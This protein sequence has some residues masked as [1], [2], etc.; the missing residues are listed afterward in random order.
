MN[1]YRITVYVIILLILI[2]LIYTIF[3]YAKG[4]MKEMNVVENFSVL[5]L[6]LQASAINSRLQASEIALEERVAPPAT[7]PVVIYTQ[8]VTYPNRVPYDKIFYDIVEISNVDIMQYKWKTM[9]YYNDPVKIVDSRIILPA[10][11]FTN[12]GSPKLKSENSQAKANGIFGKYVDVNKLN[13]DI[14]YIGASIVLARPNIHRINL[15]NFILSKGNEPTGFNLSSDETN[16]LKNTYN[17]LYEINYWYSITKTFYFDDVAIGDNMDATST[18]FEYVKYIYDPVKYVTERSNNIFASNY[19]DSYIKFLNTKL[20]YDYNSLNNKLKLIYDI[21]NGDITKMNINYNKNGKSFDECKIT[22]PTSPYHSYLS[23][24]DLLNTNNDEFKTNVNIAADLIM[25]QVISKNVT[26]YDSIFQGTILASSNEVNIKNTLVNFFNNFY[27]LN[28][29]YAL[30]AERYYYLDVNYY[31]TTPS[32]NV[33]LSFDGNNFIGGET[34]TTSHSNWL[35]GIGLDSKNRN[36]FERTNENGTRFDA[37]STD[38]MVYYYGMNFTP[39]EAD[40]TPKI[41]I[42]STDSLSDQ[43]KDP[44]LPIS[45]LYR[46]LTYV[47]AINLIDDGEAIKQLIKDRTVE[48]KKITTANEKFNIDAGKSITIIKNIRKNIAVRKYLMSCKYDDFTRIADFNNE[49]AAKHEGEKDIDTVNTITDTLDEREYKFDSFSMSIFDMLP[50]SLHR[51]TQFSNR[52]LEKDRGFTLQNIDNNFKNLDNVRTT[53]ALKVTHKEWN[54]AEFKDVDVFDHYEIS[55]LS[56]WMGLGKGLETKTYTQKG[57]NEMAKKLFESPSGLGYDVQWYNDSI[58]YGFTS[59]VASNIGRQFPEGDYKTK[60]NSKMVGWAKAQATQFDGIYSGIQDYDWK[61]YWKYY[62]N[63]PKKDQYYTP[64]DA[65]S[66]VSIQTLNSILDAE[67][68]KLTELKKIQPV[69]SDLSLEKYYGS[70]V[71]NYNNLYSTVIPNLLKSCITKLKNNITEID[72]FTSFM[73]SF[74]DLKLTNYKWETMTKSYSINK[75][76]NVMY[77]SNSSGIVNDGNVLFKH[78]EGPISFVFDSIKRKKSDNDD[79]IINIPNVG[80]SIKCAEYNLLNIDSLMSMLLFFKDINN[81]AIDAYTIDD[82]DY[83][84]YIKNSDK[85]VTSGILQDINAF[86]IRNFTDMSDI[87]SDM[88]SKYVTLKTEIEK[89]NDKIDFLP[90]FNTLHKTLLSK[91][92]LLL[93]SERQSKSVNIAQYKEFSLM[94]NRFIK[95]LDTENTFWNIYNDKIESNS[96]LKK[97]NPFLSESEEK[98]KSVLSFFDKY[99]SDNIL[100]SKLELNSLLTDPKTDFHSLLSGDGSNDPKIKKI[101]DAIETWFNYADPQNPGNTTKDRFYST[102]YNG[103]LR[104]NFFKKKYNDGTKIDFLEKKDSDY[105]NIYNHPKILMT[106]NQSILDNKTTSDFAIFDIGVILRHIFDYD[107]TDYLFER[108]TYSNYNFPTWFEYNSNNIINIDPN[109]DVLS[110]ENYKNLMINSKLNNFFDIVDTNY[111]NLKQKYSDA[112][113]V[114]FTVNFFNFIEEEKILYS[115]ITTKLDKIV[116]SRQKMNEIIEYSYTDKFTSCVNCLI[117]FYTDDTVNVIIPLYKQLSDMFVVLIEPVYDFDSEEFSKIKRHVED[118]S[119]LNNDEF[120]N[121]Y[122]K[123]TRLFKSLNNGIVNQSTDTPSGENKKTSETESKIEGSG[124]LNYLFNIHNFVLNLILRGFYYYNKQRA[125]INKYGAYCRNTFSGPFVDLV[126]DD[127]NTF[128]EPSNQIIMD[129]CGIFTNLAYSNALF[130]FLSEALLFY[131]TKICAHCYNHIF[132]NMTNIVSQLNEEDHYIYSSNEDNVTIKIQKGKMLMQTVKIYENMLDTLRN[133]EICISSLENRYHYISEIASTK[134]LDGSFTYEVLN[135]KIEGLAFWS[136]QDNAVINPS[137]NFLNPVF[138]NLKKIINDYVNT[139][140]YFGN[141]KVYGCFEGNLSKYY[142]S[143]GFSKKIEGDKIKDGNTPKLISYVNNLD[144]DGNVKKYGAITNCINDTIAYNT[145]INTDTNSAPGSSSNNKKYDLVSIVPFNTSSDKNTAVNIDTYAC[146]AGNSSGFHDSTNKTKKSLVTLSNIDKCAI[147]YTDDNGK[148][149][150]GFND[151]LTNNSIIYKIDTPSNYD[152]ETVAFLGC[153]KKDLPELGVYNTLPNFIG[154]IS[155]GSYNSD[156]HGIMRTMSDM[157]KRYND[158]FGTN[159]N[160]YGISTNITDNL[161]LDVYA[162]NS[163]IDA[164]YAKTEKRDAYQDNCNIYFPGTDNFM[165]YQD[166][167]LIR[168][169]CLTKEVDNLQKYSSMLTDYLKK[170]ISNQQKAIADI[171]NDINLFKNLFPIKF[172]ISGISNSKDFANLSID[173]E[174][175]VGFD[176]TDNTSVRTCKL[177]ITVKEGPQGPQG[178]PGISGEKGKNVKGPKGDIGNAGYWGTPKK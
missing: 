149:N 173:R 113:Y 33:I 174:N 144:S 106:Y 159:Y 77:K 171:G 55:P 46:G 63:D 118:S 23:S 18:G 67:Y 56:N 20:G 85:Y 74:K 52:D 124:V 166:K 135:Q 24:I 163:E 139:V 105:K 175:S 142:S 156:P 76:V 39:Y 162:G 22:N 100:E 51:L 119:Y 115:D 54:T 176:S 116:N 83:L 19:N 16:I 169:E 158:E 161:T 141:A 28:A 178:L 35:T 145:S 4:V 155:G 3:D 87:L 120:K 75:I 1:F 114:N 2:I 108:E 103:A 84:I 102:Y 49:I 26:D 60:Y 7:P 112:P 17:I 57:L 94:M 88:K 61:Y 70:L 73:D 130:N 143:M 131:K 25:K 97:I 93:N 132:I 34:F 123:Y 99:I 15:K 29:L 138:S 160:I 121:Y 48:N 81:S 50:Q 62:Y 13:P 21:S 44:M 177:L 110:Y 151:N 126:S 117:S 82:P 30:Y 42:L 66:K 127:K 8:L 165:I 122:K 96:L 111:N 136:V 37:D 64:G 72:S 38:K 146:Y 11:F 59:E 147:N 36:L 86:V 31:T 125:L 27:I 45:K 157:V 92:T 109:T 129:D 40:G 164:K 80:E 53:F 137:L 90:N 69:Q 5:D 68:V 107:I 12:N 128:A 32:K 65:F 104:V 152:S 153:Y 154:N 133:N 14:D 43:Y 10:S 170:N 95:Y 78:N 167:A 101:R 89:Y 140:F 134:D 71:I 168:D 9:P 150:P 148:I 41:G 47:D 98:T 6:A 172:D 91:T 58:N 79:K